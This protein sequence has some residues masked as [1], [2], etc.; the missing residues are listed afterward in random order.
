MNCRFVP[1]SDYKRDASWVC[2][3]GCSH[4][5][6]ER[7]S[8]EE[9]SRI[10]FDRDMPIRMLCFQLRLQ[11]IGVDPFRAFGHALAFLGYHRILRWQ[12]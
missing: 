11:A 7:V 4:G 8:Q 2:I 3:A 6:A 12:L 5:F 1:Y 9:I 10:R